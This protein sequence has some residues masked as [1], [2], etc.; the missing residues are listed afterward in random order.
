[1]ILQT[2]WNEYV[3][4]GGHINIKLV[5]RSYNWMYK[6][7][8]QFCKIYLAFKRG[9]FKVV[10]EGHWCLGVRE[11]E[12]GY[13]VVLPWTSWCQIFSSPPSQKVEFSRE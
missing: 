2:V 13:L 3:R 11:D 12:S 10:Q 6:R 4:F 1:M 7:K 5:T 9:C 8:P